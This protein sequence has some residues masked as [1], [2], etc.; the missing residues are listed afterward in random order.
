V[1]PNTGVAHLMLCV[2]SLAGQVVET[3]DGGLAIPSDF[4]RS[5][6]TDL[7]EAEIG[8]NYRSDPAF[9]AQMEWLKGK[10]LLQLV[11]MDADLPPKASPSVTTENGTANTS[12]S[13]R[14]STATL[15]STTQMW[16][17][18]STSQADSAALRATELA[19]HVRIASHALAGAKHSLTPG[20]SVARALGLTPRPIRA[21][22]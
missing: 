14:L 9:I 11:D 16:E 3:E 21:K 12:V 20:G 6:V 13:T 17:S 7:F 1:Q 22:L 15:V 10:E 18:N 8:S 19:H 5:F 4:V 2:F